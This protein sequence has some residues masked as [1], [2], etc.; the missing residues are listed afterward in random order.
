MFELLM[1]SALTSNPK[2]KRSLGVTN[3][4]EI[5][6]NRA[7]SRFLPRLDFTGASSRINGYGQAPGLNNLLLGSRTAVTSATSSLRLGLNVF[8][9]G[10]DVRNRQLATERKSEADL[11]LARDQL[12]IVNKLLDKYA[13]AKDLAYK[14]EIAKSKAK[15]AS[16]KKKLAETQLRQGRVSEFK[17]Q[18][19][20][21]E[22]EL[23]NSELQ[24][25]VD[26]LSSEMSSILAYAGVTEASRDK[27]PPMDLV[28]VEYESELLTQGLTIPAGVTPTEQIAQ[29][30]IT[31]ADIEVRKAYSRFSPKAEIFMEIAEGALSDKSIYYTLVH[32]SKQTSSVGVTL[33]WN[34]FD[35]L[36]STYHLSGKKQ[37]VDNAMDALDI[38]RDEA[39]QVRIETQFHL[40]QRVSEL[41]VAD[42][43]LSLLEKKLKL[44]ALEYQYGRAPEIDYLE[45]VTGLEEQRFENKIIEN[46]ISRLK[47]K[48]LLH[49][50]AK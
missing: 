24:I 21:L 11:S 44:V 42:S 25:A 47:A 34:L 26:K 37:E 32:Q 23:K 41:R 33:S 15:F 45:A 7:N 40:S 29:S 36:D 3:L 31:Q 39:H 4:A 12:E 49:G 17:Q 6:I 9:G 10:E 16:E 46:D 43:K 35:G 18:E 1:Q 48:M 30:K 2:I 13:E 19:T 5:E 38:A 20:V 8:N 28:H 27:V 50:A 14:V 22:A